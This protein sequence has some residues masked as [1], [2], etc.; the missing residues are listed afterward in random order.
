MRQTAVASMSLDPFD[1]T[2]TG[3]P[4]GSSNADLRELPPGSAL[5][6]DHAEV[7]Y[8]RPGGLERLRN[9]DGLTFR[10]L[11]EEQYEPLCRFVKGYVGSIEVAEDLVQEVFLDLWQRCA[12]LDPDRCPRAYLYGAA[13]NQALKHLRRWHTRRKVEQ[14]LGDG[15]GR[16]Q[17]S[18]SVLRDR[19]LQQ[20]V[21]QCLEA[22]P[23]RRRLI[24]ALSRQHDLTYVEIATLLDISVKTVETQMGHALRFFRKNLRA[25]LSILV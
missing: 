2:A 24:F 22:L 9:G 8:R 18:D 13:R 16:L 4:R 21:Q 3:I 6:R 25:F 12:D 11:F 5:S 15:P 17:N 19:E 14:E 23:T 7:P 10:S 20:A 1:T